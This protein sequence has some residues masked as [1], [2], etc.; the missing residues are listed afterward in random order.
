[1]EIIELHHDKKKDVRV[2]QL[3]KQLSYAQSESPFSKVRLDEEELIAGAR[4]ATLMACAPPVLFARLG[5][6]PVI[7]GNQGEGL[8]PVM[9]HDRSPS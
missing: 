2:E 7:F 3:L 1:M 6:T 8:T 4:G 5:S 9:T